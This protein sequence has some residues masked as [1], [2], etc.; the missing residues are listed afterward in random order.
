MSH[1]PVVCSTW[2]PQEQAV[3][4]ILFCLERDSPDAFIMT[5]ELLGL[6]DAADPPH[7]DKLCCVFHKVSSF[8]L[9]HS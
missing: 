5:K 2:D 8:S 6:L 4:D 9:V 1:S 3:I 7:P